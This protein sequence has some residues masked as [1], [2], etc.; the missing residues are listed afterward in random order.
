MFNSILLFV[1]L[2]IFLFP[3]LYRKT[4][5]TSKAPDSAAIPEIDAPDDEHAQYYFKCKRVHIK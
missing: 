5:K 1:V 4:N 3:L 2:F